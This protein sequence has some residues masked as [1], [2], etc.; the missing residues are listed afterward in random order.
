MKKTT[1]KKIDIKPKTH[2]TKTIA[3]TANSSKTIVES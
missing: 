2:K 1:L 3:F